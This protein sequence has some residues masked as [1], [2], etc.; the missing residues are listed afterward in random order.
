MIEWLSE[1]GNIPFFASL[2]FGLMLTAYILIGGLEDS[3]VNVHIDADGDADHDYNM[4]DHDHDFGYHHAF[5]LW[6]GAGR[7]PASI[8]LQVLA[9]SFGFFGLLVGAV[10]HDSFGT[11]WL[12]F[13]V[14]YLVAVPLSLVTTRAVGQIFIKLMPR[15][16]D[17]PLPKA[18]RFVGEVAL[19][20][21]SI[22]VS[23]FGQIRVGDAYLSAF[24][25]YPISSGQRAVIVSYDT[26]RHAYM[27]EHVES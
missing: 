8:L 12:S 17:S 19:V 4:F 22:P 7:A 14:A 20:S 18:E 16:V 10:C 3:D 21:S 26:T 11:S 6:I 5:V 23:G 13:L 24:A 9:L 25:S 1:Y 15:E 2:L 27:V